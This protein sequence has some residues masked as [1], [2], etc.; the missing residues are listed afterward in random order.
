[1]KV[2]ENEMLGLYEVEVENEICF[3][4]IIKKLSK[5]NYFV[6]G[7]NC[8]LFVLVIMTPLNVLAREVT[9][10]KLESKSLTI[11]TILR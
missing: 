11:Q 5:E 2:L 10:Q 6:K 1:M 7:F 8:S 3:W 9:T 4:E